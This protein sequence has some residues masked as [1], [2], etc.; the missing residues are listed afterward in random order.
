MKAPF[1]FLL[2]FIISCTPDKQQPTETPRL[3]KPSIETPQNPLAETLI[4]LV[5]EQRQK[6]C[7]C[8]QVKMPPAPPLVWN[9]ALSSTAL[10]HSQEMEKEEHFSHDGKD[11][12]NCGQRLTRDGYKWSA[13]GENIFF[14]SD[15]P[16]D[17]V[18]SWIKSPPHCKTL[19]KNIYTEFGVGKSGLYWTQ[20]FG[21]PLDANEIN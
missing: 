3:P 12:S 13:F 2:V 4:R 17:A 8:G 19:M 10:K 1:F 18:H 14:G 7:I 6:G 5:N 20:I 15:N 9:D 21:K 11:G 16:E